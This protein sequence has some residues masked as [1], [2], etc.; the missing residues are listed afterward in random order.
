MEWTAVALWILAGVLVV[1]GVGGTALPVLPGAL[2]V[3]C[4]LLLGAWIDGFEKV[5][6]WTLTLIGVLAGLTYAVD[7][8]ASALGAQRVGASRRALVGAVAGGVVGLF[9]GILG[10][11]VGPFMGA[12]IGE[13]TVQ[14]NLSQAGRVGVG[15]WIGMA[16]GLAAKLALV[17]TMIGTFVIALRA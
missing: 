6:G 4:G 11:L 1:V 8:A 9:F 17:F 5:G 7:F 12:V 2:L 3:F 13:Y 15:T 14:R 16:L 10:V